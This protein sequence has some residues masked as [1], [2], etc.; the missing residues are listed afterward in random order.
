[1][2]FNKLSSPE[3]L[4]NKDKSTLFLY[5]QYLD[6]KNID[7]S[8]ISIMKLTFANQTFLNTTEVSLIGSKIFL[9]D[10]LYIV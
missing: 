2:N 10:A 3:V 6:Y 9:V 1:M 4:N 5:Q 7:P 8:D